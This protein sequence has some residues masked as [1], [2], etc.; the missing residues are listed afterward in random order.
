MELSEAGAQG[1]AALAGI[2]IEG[3]GQGLVDDLAVEIGADG[4][5]EPGGSPALPLGEAF[6]E[7][8][9]VLAGQ[10]GQ[11]PVMSPKQFSTAIENR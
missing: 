4:L 9:L 1:G 8:E 2:L 7:P 11:P 10:A 5:L 3:D 6:V